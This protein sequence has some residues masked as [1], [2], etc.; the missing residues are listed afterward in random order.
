V[1]NHRIVEIE[2]EVA[3]NEVLLTR[4]HAFQPELA[5]SGKSRFSSEVERLRTNPSPDAPKTNAPKPVPYDEMILRLLE[6]I[7][8]EAREGAG[9]DEGK[10][11][12]LLQERLEFHVKKL[13]DVTEERRMERD[14]LLKEKAKHI[15][16]D[17]IHDG[18]SSKVTCPSA[19]ISST[20]FTLK[21]SSVCS[22]KARTSPG[23][24]R[25]KG[26]EY[27]QD[28]PYRGT[29]P[30]SIFI[31]AVYYYAAIDFPRTP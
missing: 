25:G 12:K 22:S 8:N 20:Q 28:D 27:H 21:S 11:E 14:D 15:T 23:Y 4:L 9:S 5:Q 26:K 2:A 31:C 10:L 30:R 18:F 19:V 1:R 3:C 29:Q 24:W 16:M 7:A 17:D 6:T 13:G